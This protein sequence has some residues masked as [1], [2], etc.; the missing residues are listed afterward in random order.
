MYASTDMRP[1]EYREVGRQDQIIGAK[2]A[3]QQPPVAIALDQLEKELHCLREL[4]RV[5]EQRLV[6][7][8]RPV[9]ETAATSGSGL[10]CGSPL[11][12][13][14]EMLT[15]LAARSSNDVRGMLD[16]LEL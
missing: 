16:C 12:A 11:A 7:V 1:G 4:M 9:P 6:P 14:I 3:Q 5:L 10:A 8:M 13:Q 2:V 15:N